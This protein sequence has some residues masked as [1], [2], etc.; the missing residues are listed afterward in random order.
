MRLDGQTVNAPHYFIEALIKKI[1]FPNLEGY[2]KFHPPIFHHQTAQWEPHYTADIEIW[3]FNFSPMENEEQ[4]FFSIVSNL[5]TP[6]ERFITRQT[7]IKPDSFS[8]A[9]VGRN[10]ENVLMN[11]HPYHQKSPLKSKAT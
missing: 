5:L 1:R 6:V 2:L 9:L 7:N 8:D 3:I 4:V 10:V 11:G